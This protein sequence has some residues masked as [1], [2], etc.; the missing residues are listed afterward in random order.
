MQPL[1]ACHVI[2]LAHGIRQL[3]ICI[4]QRRLQAAHGLALVLHRTR[5]AVSH[6]PQN[7]ACGFLAR[8][9]SIRDHFIDVSLRHAVVLCQRADRVNAALLQ[10]V[11]V[12]ERGLAGRVHASDIGGYLIHVLHGHAERRARITDNLQRRQDVILVIAVSV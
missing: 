10:G 4:L 11:D 6:C 8:D 12:L 3:G 5:K 9:L 7:H 1:F 2:A